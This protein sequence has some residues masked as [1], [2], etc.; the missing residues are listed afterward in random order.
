MVEHLGLAA[1]S[2]V[3][4]KDWY[5]HVLDGKVVFTDGQT[6]PIFFVQLPGGLT[7]EIYQANA[8]MKETSNNKLAG[9]RHVAL[10][11]DSIERAK[12]QLER[13]GITFTETLKPAAGGGHVLFFQ[14]GEGNLLHLLERPA[15]TPFGQAMAANASRPKAA[16]SQTPAGVRPSNG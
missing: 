10:R 8:A 14:D 5:V 6:P 7:L 9:L 11:V 15:D 3:A 13:N 1:T 2:P 4:L 12:A 16:R